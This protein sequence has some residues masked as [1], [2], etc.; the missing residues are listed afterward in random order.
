ML[1]NLPKFGYLGW[2]TLNDSYFALHRDIPEEYINFNYKV[3]GGI[4]VETGSIA[5]QDE[6]HSG[7]ALNRI[8]DDVTRIEQCG[9]YYALEIPTTCEYINLDCL[10]KCE[11]LFVRGNEVNE[12]LKSMLEENS[13][14][15]H[16][17]CQDE[18]LDVYGMLTPSAPHFQQ[19][20]NNE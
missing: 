14:N 18:Y 1:N 4:Y 16:I 3:N 20:E 17:L 7:V 5:Y 12:N 8:P 11:Y 6:P 2:E 19:V 15:I 9:L 13:L 10:S